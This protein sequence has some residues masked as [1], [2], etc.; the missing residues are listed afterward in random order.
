M[1]PGLAFMTYAEFNW[2]MLHLPIAPTALVHWPCFLQDVPVSSN[3][4]FCSRHAALFTMFYVVQ[5]V[6]IGVGL[7]LC[8]IVYLFS[9][10][11]VFSFILQ[12][13][14]RALH[15]LLYYGV[16]WRSLS[17][18]SFLFSFHLLVISFSAVS[19]F[20]IQEGRLT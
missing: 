14:Y 20:D 2:R 13:A 5:V 10:R 6:L 18:F 8:F 9:R 7:F 12:P 1:T 4:L 16:D 19:Q 15:H 17:S 11:D 3:I